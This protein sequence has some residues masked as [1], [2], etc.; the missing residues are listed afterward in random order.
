MKRFYNYFLSLLLLLTAGVTSVMAQGYEQGDL[1]DT[2]EAATSQDV[3]FYA[4]GQH[5]QGYMAGTGA[6][7]ASISKKCFYRLEATGGTVDGHK[8]YRIK[9]V[10]TGLY[11]KNFLLDEGQE[12]SGDLGGFDSGDNIDMTE[13]ADEALQVTC[14]LAEKHD[15]NNPD[16]KITD[17]NKYAFAT[18]GKNAEQDLSMAAFV[19]R[20]VK[21]NVGN[22][23]FGHLGKPFH[24]VYTD[25]NA[26]QLYTYVTTEGRD[27]LVAY[28]VAFYGTGNEDPA[29][30]YPA[31]TTPGTYDAALVQ[32]AHDVWQKVFDNLQIEGEF[33][34]SNEEVNKLCDE[35]ESTIEALKAPGARHSLAAGRYFIHDSRDTKLYLTN[36][37]VGKEN[38]WACSTFTM[39]ETIDASVAN[40][41]WEVA[42]V[43]TDSISLKHLA[44]GLYVQGSMADDH[45]YAFGDQPHPIKVEF[46]T[47]A[48]NGTFWLRPNAG[49]IACTNGAGWMLSWTDANDAGNHFA[50]D[51]A[52]VDDNT[53]AQWVAEAQQ[54]ALNTQ[55]AEAYDAANI[56][57]NS[58]YAYGNDFST[59]GALVSKGW[60]SNAKS[61]A[62][63][64]YENLLDNN[65]AT[66]FHSDYSK[67]FT[68]SLEENHYLAAAL[69][70]PATGEIAIKVG[71]RMTGNDFP[72][73]FAVYGAAALDTATVEGAFQDNTE[74][75]YLGNADIYYSDSLGTIAKGVGLATINIEGSYNC[76]KLA[77]IK[78]T[79]NM[80]AP[81]PNRGYFAISELNVWEAADI[82]KTLTPEYAELKQAA[83]EVY[84]NLETQLAAALKEIEAE[85]AT[86]AQ[87]E[88][89]NA[90]VEDFNN[91]LPNPSRVTKALATAKAFLDAAN[92]NN[93]IG[94][95][96]A[97]YDQTAA[98]NLQTVIDQYADFDKVD[99]AS[100]NA[101][102]EAIN[103]ALNAFKASVKLP[104]AGQ[105]YVIRS[106]STKVV[107]E[108]EK[109]AQGYQGAIYNAIV[110]SAN[111]NKSSELAD[112][113]SSIRFIFADHSSEV[114][115]EGETSLDQMMG[116]LKDSVDISK[117]A[118]F[119][120]KAEAAKDGKM[121]LR[122]LATG[123]YLTGANGKMYQSIEATPLLAEGVSAGV[124]RF[125]LGEN[126]QG[127]TQYM[128][129]K[130]ATGTVV[131]WKGGD[132]PNSYW[133][134]QKLNV[135]EFATETYAVKGVKKDN[136]YAATF[137]VSVNADEDAIPY[138]V[139]GISEDK[140][141][142]VLA[143]A[144]TI[145]AGVP[146]VYY[147]D[148]VAGANGST[149]GTAI[150]GCDDLSEA[151]Y[152]FEPKEAHGMGGAL[153]EP[154]KI[155]EKAAYLNNA[156]VVVKG[157]ATIG[158]NGAY[159]TGMSV[160]TEKGDAQLEL[161]KDVADILTGIDAT[162]VVVLP[163]VVD[164]YSIDGQ[165]IRKGVK[166]SNAA[167]NLPAGV[168]V[169]GGQKVLVK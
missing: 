49:E 65:P 101:A 92:T 137:P 28:Q 98:T 6:F 160:T 19:L 93:M 34:L 56:L 136:Y 158:V 161:G 105:Y 91:N 102:V 33:P 169:I 167:K 143:E 81:N 48:P 114:T 130:G 165:L 77:A 146:F 25:T 37:L 26:W 148:V 16:D 61:P 121:V 126:A 111:N 127:V 88:A 106:A 84:A 80:S 45:H 50:F 1:I 68:P 123:M 44:T 73:Q 70:K 63:G 110:Y 71:K 135:G 129:T 62:E 75:K 155:D 58:G 120:W 32:A 109:G 74:W 41:L 157:G 162:K 149:V 22:Q 42:I 79:F 46:T 59:A 11:V 30:T 122:N 124:F 53:L 131:S 35:I 78:T 85:K 38:A 145:P 5:G 4:T 15:I 66:Y 107:P 31:G 108:D 24:S 40:Y 119:V 87:L 125:N 55:L 166:S 128:N 76:L 43:G 86:K 52:D 17:E 23:Y 163:S 142:L 97:Q 133:K 27:R 141:H 3:L 150:F 51:V 100:I 117:D 134:V 139:V 115:P 57:F 9:Q 60:Y 132:D 54:K 47:T 64:S 13:S 138:T 103:G 2:E 20:V 154:V 36:T 67:A 116:N 144:E 168:Y 95:E 140:T 96:L 153:C 12:D 90:A 8:I 113:A 39:P 99:L 159:F 118:S 104:E 18:E 152:V 72:L 151:E 164:V 156:G 89:L 10:K 21:S 147:V 29:V 83:P 7:T 94:E 112:A 82:T 69:D 14:T